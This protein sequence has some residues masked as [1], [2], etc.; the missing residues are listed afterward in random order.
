M[1]AATTDRAKR[2]GIDLVINNSLTEA[3]IGKRVVAFHSDPNKALDKALER[4]EEDRLRHLDP[5]PSDR[6][7]ILKTPKKR[8]KPERSPFAATG[9][10]APS[11]APPPKVVALPA[12][13]APPPTIEERIDEGIKQTIIKG[14]IIKPK[15]KDRYKKNGFSCGDYISGE[16]RE[17][18]VVLVEGRSRLSLERL[19]EVAETNGVWRDSY[20]LLNPGQQRMNVGNRLRAKY[21]AGDPIDIGGS[22]TQKEIKEI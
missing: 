18:V 8:G 19:R 17:Y 4:I 21:E 16:L 1:L 6:E 13:T 5:L 11:A 15:Y 7:P 10:S 12:L 2:A 9:G 20:K 22:I 3:R 14:S